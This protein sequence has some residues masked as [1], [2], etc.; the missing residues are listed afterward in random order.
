[1]LILLATGAFHPTITDPNLGMEV[2]NRFARDWRDPTPNEGYHHLLSLTP[3]D[4]DS[5]EYTEEVVT[6]IIDRVKAMPRND[7]A[8]N[9]QRSYRHYYRPYNNKGY[10]NR[11]GYYDHPRGSRGGRHYSRWRG[12]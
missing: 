12:Q 3:S 6:N 7:A 11:R 9:W 4:Q 5:M 1:M 10:N 8:L 2:L